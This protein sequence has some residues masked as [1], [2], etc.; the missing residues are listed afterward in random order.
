MNRIERPRRVSAWRRRLLFPGEPVLRL[1]R[2]NVGWLLP[3]VLLV[4]IAFVDTTTSGGIRVITWIVLVPGIAAALSGVPVTA[5]YAVASAVVYEL[6]DSADA[7]GYEEGAGDFWLVVAGGG[8]AVIASWLRGRAQAL[9]GRVVDAAEATRLAVLRPIPPGS[10]GLE[11]ASAYLAADV[12]TRVGGDFFD[13]QPSPHGTRVLLGDVQGKGT[14]AVDAAAA[15]LGSFREAAF[16]EAAL[17]VVAQRLESRMRR[18]NVYAG[19]L[20]QTEERFA[21]A[22]LVGFPPRDEGWVELVNFGHAGPLAIGPD[23]Q[24]RAL[25]EGAGTPL[26]L[27][28]LTGELPAVLRVPLDPSETLL[29]VT[30][31]VTEARD[32]EGTFLPLAERLARGGTD[33]SPAEVVRLVQAAVQA[34]TEGRLEDDTAMLAVRRLPAGAGEEPYR[35]EPAVPLPAS[36]AAAPAPGATRPDS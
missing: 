22:V 31:G 14:S 24:V 4:A 30:D 6:I 35:D 11:S 25:P 18:H 20:G 34:H 8:L 28:G 23:G 33:G 9:L 17:A 27:T 7:S 2:W 21:T 13:V 1:G 12:E 10:G 36:P 29:M 15:L 16:Y 5:L 3:A 19:E 32:R 26:G